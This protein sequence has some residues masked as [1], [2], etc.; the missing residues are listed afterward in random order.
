MRVCCRFE[1]GR[2]ALRLGMVALV[3]AWCESSPAQAPK[4]APGTVPPP[5]TKAPPPGFPK[6][7]PPKT[8][9][10]APKALPQPTPP[11]AQPKGPPKG[12]AKGDEPTD[13]TLV[14][15]DGV[16]VR[17]T[18]YLGSAK[19]E[20]VPIIMLH[21]AEGQRGDFHSLATYLQ[22]QGHSII[23]PDLRGHGDS[24]RAEGVTQPLD[25][26]KFNRQSYESMVL[27]VEA[28]KK[29]L[30]EKNNA[31][32]L[33]IDQLCVIGAE[34]G[35]IVAVRWAALDWSVQDLPAYRQGKDV[36]ALV[37]LS[38]LNS[39]KGITIRD[40]LKHPALESQLSMMIVAGAKDKSASEAKRLHNSLLA[41]HPKV[42]DDDED[43]LKK[44]EVFLVQPDTPLSGTKLLGPGLPVQQNIA[45]FIELRLVNRKSEFP[46]TERK[47]PLSN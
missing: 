45:K 35:A 12:K 8:N 24:T 21:G 29:Y 6:G 7:P 27:D 34:L 4:K 5:G 41:H 23:V 40:A 1:L 2:C 47:S 38:P 43:R 17:A 3:L 28:C 33:N 11:K 14:T 13:E 26:E 46:W 37:L 19:K 42:S 36:K 10:T 9:P 18:F 16:S 31:G 22:G 30:M 20:S 15:K 32:E 39:F 44:Q 25:A